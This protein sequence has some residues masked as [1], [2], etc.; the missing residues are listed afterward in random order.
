[1]LPESQLD[2]FI[3]KL[4]MGYPD[5]NSEINIIKSKQNNNPMS[6][7]N[8]VLSTDDILYMQQLADCVYIDDKVYLYIARLIEATRKHPL[9]K[10]G[11]SPRGTLALTNMAK[12]TALI[13]C[14]DYVIPDDV[15]YIFNDVVEHR[16]LLN[17]K[18]RINDVTVK[19][20]LAE[21]IS[22]VPV[23]EINM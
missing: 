13:R 11:V 8:S 21:I 6:Q 17:S 1:M 23:P 3:I 20:V 9:I 18:A 16:I 19:S 14:R 7:V 10:L 5:I 22:N 12:S 4:S 15:T 2:R